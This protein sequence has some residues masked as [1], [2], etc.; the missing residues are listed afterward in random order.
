MGLVKAFFKIIS[1]SL[2]RSV[3]WKQVMQVACSVLA[4]LTLVGDLSF[5]TMRGWLHLKN[6]LL[7]PLARPRWLLALSTLYSGFARS[8]VLIQGSMGVERMFDGWLLPWANHHLCLVWVR[9]IPPLSW[10]AAD[11]CSYEDV[12]LLPL[13][14]LSNRLCRNLTGMTFPKH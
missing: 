6:A 14:S 3:Q 9:G 12:G 1:V 7:P 13:T 10:D 8:L 4:R 11:A 5:C 2:C